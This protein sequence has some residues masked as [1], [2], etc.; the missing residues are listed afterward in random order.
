ML[1]DALLLHRVAGDELVPRFLT[2]ADHV[3]LRAL[4]DVRQ[5]CVGLLERELWKRL[6][7]PLASEAPEDKRRLATHVLERGVRARTAAPVV[8]RKARAALFGAAA[9]STSTTLVNAEQVF[10]QAACEL[11]VTAGAVRDSLFADLPGERRVEAEA[12]M[13]SPAEMALRCNLALAQGLLFRSRR[14]RISLLG[15]ARAVV[16]QARLRGLLC[17]VGPARAVEGPGGTAGTVAGAV[18]GASSEDAGA[19]AMVEIS[20]PLSLFRHTLVY[21]RRLAELVPLLAWCDRYRLDAECLVRGRLRRVVLTSGDPIAPSHEPR[22]YDSKLE[23]RFA[24]DFKRIAPDWQLVREP[25]PVVAGAALVFPDFALLHARE[26][27]RR[28]LL[29][30]VGFWTPEYLSEKLARYR[31]AGLPNL[32]LC[33]D[34]ARGCGE[35]ELPAEARVVRFSRWIDPVVVLAIVEGRQDRG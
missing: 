4:L 28:F 24:R 17:N 27:G 13:L 3:W 12:N 32:I 29:E 23:A 19:T 35:G 20:G 2:E 11:Q 7:G 31:A 14:V 9:R 15:N 21:G 6:E 30:I 26:P 34:Q 16:R 5:A 33:I 25:E 1:P 10:A 18:V 8:P 22:R